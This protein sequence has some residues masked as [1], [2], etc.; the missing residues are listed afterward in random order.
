MYK[1]FQYK[2]ISENIWLIIYPSKNIKIKKSFTSES[3][4][5]AFIDEIITWGNN[6]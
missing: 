2:L 6:Q 4:V 3:Q 5:K 1:E